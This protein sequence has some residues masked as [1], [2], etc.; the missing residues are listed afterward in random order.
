MLDYNHVNSQIQFN[1]QKDICHVV[2]CSSMQ[3]RIMGQC[4]H[5][6]L[7]FLGLVHIYYMSIKTQNTYTLMLLCLKI[8]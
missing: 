4:S 5:F 8:D 6:L 1:Q 3:C 2:N 7:H